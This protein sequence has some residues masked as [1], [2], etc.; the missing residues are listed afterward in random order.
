M[1]HR[2]RHETHESNRRYTIKWCRECGTI[3]LRIGT[4]RMGIMT[5]SDP[6]LRP[7]LLDAL[8]RAGRR[9]DRG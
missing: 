3:H 4:I 9:R 8:I 5:A 1:I 2:D 6:A 7:I